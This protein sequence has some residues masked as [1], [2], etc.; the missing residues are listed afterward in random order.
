MQFKANATWRGSGKDGAGRLS[1]ASKVLDETPYSYEIRFEGAAGTSPE[2][3][4]AAA[5]A[6]CFTMALAFQLQAAGYTATE[7]ATEAVVT[8]A[9]QNGGFQ[10]TRSALRLDATIPGIDR[11]AFDEIASKAEAGCPVSKL[12]NAEISLAATLR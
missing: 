8:L 2:E 7:L 10:I 5:H 3:L 1:T 6:G 11:Q 12:L 9:S 4:I